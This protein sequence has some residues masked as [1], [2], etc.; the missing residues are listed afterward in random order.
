MPS[1]QTRRPI[2]RSVRPE[3]PPTIVTALRSGRTR[4]ASPPPFV[5]PVDADDAQPESAT[6]TTAARPP[7]R[8][9][10]PGRCRARSE[11]RADAPGTARPGGWTLLTM[12]SDLGGDALTLP[13]YSAF[14]SREC[15]LRLT[16]GAGIPLHPYGDSGRQ[17]SGRCGSMCGS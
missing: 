5:A 6:A 10:T 4:L 16:S 11:M 12:A 15:D 1:A 14:V 7:T 8:T 2:R 13:R 9:R 17:L 3:P